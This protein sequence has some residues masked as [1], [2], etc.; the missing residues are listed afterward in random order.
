MVVDAASTFNGAER[1][2]KE[3]EADGRRRDSDNHAKTS[4]K[5]DDDDEGKRFN[6]LH[7]IHTQWHTKTDGWLKH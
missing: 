5:G 1:R 3:E 4:Q 6:G 2:N 7:Y